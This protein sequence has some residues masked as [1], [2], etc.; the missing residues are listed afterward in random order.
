MIEVEIDVH[1]EAPESQAAIAGTRRIGRIEQKNAAEYIAA[2]IED[3]IGALGLVVARALL[4]E[5]ARRGWREEDDY[6]EDERAQR[7]RRYDLCGR[8][9]SPARSKTLA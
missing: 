6:D 4:V 7:L 2:D 1:S 3:G 8:A 9:S 5:R